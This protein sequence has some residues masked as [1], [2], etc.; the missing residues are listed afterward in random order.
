MA[1]Q[2]VP[3]SQYMLPAYEGM[4]VDSRDHTI[5]SRTVESVA[6]LGYGKAEFQ[7][8]ADQGI[9]NAADA[10]DTT[11]KLL[12]FAEAGHFGSAGIADLWARYETVPIVKKGPIWL[13]ASVAVVA[14]DLAY[15]VLA[16]GVLTNVVGTNVL[17]GRFE[18]SGAGGAIV[19]VDLD[20]A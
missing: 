9:V 18:T 10:N 11:G 16:T 4:I 7:G 20:I 17:V 5:I 8:A 15:A 14:G 1:I 6:G 12:G 19:V 13:L 3:Y 2:P